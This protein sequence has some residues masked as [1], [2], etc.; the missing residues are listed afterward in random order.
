MAPKSFSIH[1]VDKYALRQFVKQRV[2][3]KMIIFV[4]ETALNVIEC[5]PN[6]TPPSLKSFINHL[7]I[8]SDVSV[9]TF[10]ST[11]VYLNRLKST[12][13]PTIRGKQTTAHRLFLG[14]L[15]LSTKYLDDSS[16]KNKDWAEHTN[17]AAY[18]FGFTG[19]DVNNIERHLLSL[20]RYNLK[21]DEDDLYREL[22]VF[23]GPLCIEFARE[24]THTKRHRKEKKRQ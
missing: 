18:E 13:S 1:R 4:A 21:I 23:L 7:V 16:P 5:D 3:Y 17:I 6:N 19:S 14:A 10:M 11:L 9:I 8:S 20:L 24:F 22:H 12:I 2:N 15:I